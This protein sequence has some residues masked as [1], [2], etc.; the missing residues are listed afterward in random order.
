MIYKCN[1]DQEDNYF[2]MAPP[3]P[4]PLLVWILLSVRSRYG[5]EM[6][7]M[8][9]FLTLNRDYFLLLINKEVLSKSYPISTIN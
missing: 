3:G 6:N 2:F 5:I 4:L 1:Q 9:I 7:K 8:V